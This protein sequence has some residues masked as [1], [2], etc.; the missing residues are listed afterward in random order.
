MAKAGKLVWHLVKHE[1]NGGMEV[2]RHAALRSDGVLLRKT[3]FTYEDW[4]GKP[5]KK[6]G[7]WTVWTRRPKPDVRD[8]LLARGYEER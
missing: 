5:R 2:V 1:D 8:I 4:N 3:D 6:Y 7:R